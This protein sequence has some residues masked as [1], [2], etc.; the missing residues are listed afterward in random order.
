MTRGA[1]Q[2]TTLA[3]NVKPQ[4]ARNRLRRTFGG[5]HRPS[6]GRGRRRLHH[7]AG[8]RSRSGVQSDRGHRCVGEDAGGYGRPGVQACPGGVLNKTQK[9]PLSGCF[10]RHSSY[11]RQYSRLRAASF[12]PRTGAGMSAFFHG[13][14]VR[15][16]RSSLTAV[17][18][19]VTIS[20]PLSEP[21]TS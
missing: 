20:M 14:S 2:H 18:L 19:A 8:H 3:R 5:S 6:L 13:G 21:S 12:S 7:L 10:L 16:H 11:F 15:T 17:P 9:A 4:R 1:A